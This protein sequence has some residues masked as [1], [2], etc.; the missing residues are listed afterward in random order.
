M[1]SMFGNSFS[2][3]AFMCAF[4]YFCSYF[5]H[6]TTASAHSLIHSHVFVCLTNTLY[7]Y[8]H[9]E[10]ENDVCSP[11]PRAHCSL[12]TFFGKLG[13]TWFIYDSQICIMI[14][15]SNW[16]DYIF[17]FSF[18]LSFVF[19]AIS[20]FWHVSGSNLL[21][22]FYSLFFLTLSLSLKILALLRNIGTIFIWWK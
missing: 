16:H 6:F 8:I 5:C 15:T 18:V 1:C 2:N 12:C 9:T 19:I 22:F 21:L 10:R 4:C 13:S 11:C 7:T 3:S 20:C 17:M 14:A